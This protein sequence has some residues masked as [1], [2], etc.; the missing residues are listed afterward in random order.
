M[1]CTRCAT[2]TAPFIRFATP[3][4]VDR[5]SLFT[6]EISPRDNFLNEKLEDD[7][8]RKRIPLKNRYS[9]MI[10]IRPDYSD[11]CT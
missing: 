2:G 9:L 8:I 1:V 11:A 7:W 3:S 10:H 6:G 4:D 5:A